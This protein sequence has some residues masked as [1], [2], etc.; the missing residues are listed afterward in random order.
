MTLFCHELKYNHYSGSCYF[1]SKSQGA[2]SEEPHLGPQPQVETPDRL[3]EGGL[4]RSFILQN[5]KVQL[6]ARV[7]VTQPHI[8]VLFSG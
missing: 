2:T 1:W 3:Q 7:S 8:V 6:S 4:N 5:K